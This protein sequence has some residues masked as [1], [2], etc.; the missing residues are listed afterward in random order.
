MNRYSNTD[1]NK[2]LTAN[3][4]KEII[5][6]FLLSR[7]KNGIIG[8]EVMYGSSR[9][10]ADM[11]FISKGHS[12]AIEIKSEFDTTNRLENQLHEYYSLFD[13]VL[14]FTAPNHLKAIKAVIP[15][16]VGLYCISEQGI[17]KIEREK[18]NRHIQKF[19]MLISIPSVAI[20]NK[21]SIKGKLTSDEIR[22]VAMR[23]SYKSIHDF[24][25]CYYMEKLST[26]KSINNTKTPLILIENEDDYIII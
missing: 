6:S 21:F 15:D 12:Y 18:L 24:F 23:K 2:R 26:R 16:Y 5:T 25:I 9:C 7:D 11:I 13:Y 8:Y 22:L 14:V 10:V 4:L 3:I 1:I 19:E 20:K 17:Q